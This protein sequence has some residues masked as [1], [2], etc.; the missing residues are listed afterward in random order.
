MNNIYGKR[1][2][3]FIGKK[4]ILIQMDKN[5][6]FVRE[7]VTGEGERILRFFFL[8]LNPLTVLQRFIAN[9]A[10]CYISKNVSSKKYHQVN[11]SR[12]KD[13]ENSNLK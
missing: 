11:C 5:I 6:S 2:H 9:V 7:M 13:R 4:E 3:S 8:K 1:G 12:C 10:T